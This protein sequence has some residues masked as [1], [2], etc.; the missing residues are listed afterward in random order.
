MVAIS[1]VQALLIVAVPL[2][3]LKLR[4]TKAVKGIGMIGM[5][6]LLGIGVSLVV[7]LLNTI[8]IEFSL[9]KD[10]GE[11]G[12]YLAIAVAIPLL[13]FNAN[14]KEATK[15]SRTVGKSIL[16]LFISLAAVTAITFFAF[17]SRLA[18]ADILAGM[19][20]GLY[21]GGTPNLNAIGSA[22]GLAKD[23]IALANLADMMIGGVF[24]VFLL[25]AAKPLVDKLLGK[26]K[27]SEY[28]TADVKVENYESLE[29]VPL[30]SVKGVLF[31]ILLAT[32]MALTSALIGVVIWFMLGA[33]DGELFTYLVP[34]LL[35]G[36]TVFGLI[37]SF[38]HNI[39]EVRGNNLVGQYL[40][41]VFSFALAS[42]LDLSRIGANF[43]NIILFFAIITVGTFIIH[44][45]LSRIFKVETDCTL[46]V[47]TAGLYGPAFVPAVAKQI[48]NERMIVP[49]LIVGSLGYAVGTFLGIGVALLLGIF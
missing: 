26:Y 25:V 48:K 7:F 30:K 2:L 21:T 41:L 39:R 36:V 9:N 16:S 11:I 19:A 32:L 34:A 22:L 5:T 10:I 38:N 1:I 40:I 31:C 37:G 35:I 44:I 45:L 46:I 8:G 49:G 4:D 27:S 33:P 17:R 28:L 13:L 29:H 6:Y 3:V 12:S 47:L 18:D 20:M 23:T 42:A 15:L 43:V 24:Y 14:L